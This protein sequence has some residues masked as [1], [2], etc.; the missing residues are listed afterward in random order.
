MADPEIRS[1]ENI[2]FFSIL[3]PSERE[4]LAKRC[5][6]KKVRAE[7][8]ILG[9]DSTD[10][11]IYFITRGVIRI[12]NFGPNGKEIS[13]ADIGQG[14][15]FGELSAIDGKPRSATVVALKDT[16]MAVMRPDVF[17]EALEQ[18]PALAISLLR[19]LTALVRVSSDRVLQLSTF[20][21]NSRVFGEIQ[22]QM[23]ERGRKQPDGSILLSPSPIHSDIATRIST[24]RETVARAFSLLVKRK[25]L[26]RVKGG[27]EIVSTADFEKVIEEY[28]GE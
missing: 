26:R 7:E 8:Q 23:H 9:R 25:I 12:V 16:H 15:F 1:L 24:T 20:S 28:A 21:A 4:A 22:R 6:W 5:L 18:H 14:E 2:R 13:L 3:R 27:V 10:R 11:D 19:K 17:L